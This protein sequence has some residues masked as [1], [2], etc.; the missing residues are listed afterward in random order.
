[1]L[2][3]F[4]ILVRPKAAKAIPLVSRQAGRDPLD[5]QSADQLVCRFVHFKMP[6]WCAHLRV[7]L[8]GILHFSFSIRDRKTENAKCRRSVRQGLPVIIPCASNFIKYF[9][10]I[11]FKNIE[12]ENL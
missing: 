2:P 7:S 9:I 11:F 6:A 10:S 3:I 5:R 8:F 4:P 12:L 1:M